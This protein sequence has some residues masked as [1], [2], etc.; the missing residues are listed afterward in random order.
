MSDI[1]EILSTARSWRHLFDPSFQFFQFMRS[2]QGIR[3]GKDAMPNF[4]VSP[5]SSLL[6]VLRKLAAVKTHQIWVTQER[7]LVG[8][9]S[10]SQILSVLV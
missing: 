8:V 7:A 5:D 10:I 3:Q 6:S 1:K 4:S 2:E 9:V